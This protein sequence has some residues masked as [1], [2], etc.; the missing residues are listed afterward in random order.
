MNDGK[1]ADPKTKA[2]EYSSHSIEEIEMLA[3]NDHGDV[4]ILAK[5]KYCR[6][7]YLDETLLCNSEDLLIAS[8][9]Q[10]TQPQTNGLY[11]R[12]IRLTIVSWKRKTFLNRNKSH[13]SR[14]P[15]REEGKCKS[16][17]RG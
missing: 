4:S 15:R 17:V 13:T 14:G 1:P 7:S 2:P 11:E 9:I 3:W 8:K 6:T 16:A 5:F 10:S 12:N